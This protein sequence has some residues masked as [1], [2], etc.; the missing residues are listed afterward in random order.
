MKIYKLEVIVKI[1]ETSEPENWLIT[2]IDELLEPE[3]G[4]AVIKYRLT[5][6]DSVEEA[7][8]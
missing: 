5:K 2:A 8:T 1:E 4:E 6:F 3:T 7:L